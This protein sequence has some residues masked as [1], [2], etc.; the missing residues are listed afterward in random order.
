MWVKNWS[1]VQNIFVTRMVW[2]CNR[3]K[4][5]KWFHSFY[6][7]C[8]LKLSSSESEKLNMHLLKQTNCVE[9]GKIL[10]ITDTIFVMGAKPHDWGCK[11]SIYL[12]FII[13]SRFN[14]KLIHHITLRC[15]KSLLDFCSPNYSYYFILQ[16]SS[17]IAPVNI[18]ETV[19]LTATT[20]SY[21]FY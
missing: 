12:H 18:R 1:K 9:L 3:S 15:V 17:I 10:N 19:G 11:W 13:S 21:I 6:F 16:S 4:R 20:R 14:L 7:F 8:V 2:P 5:K